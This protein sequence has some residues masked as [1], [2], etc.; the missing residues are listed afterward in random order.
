[1]WIIPYRI[2][3]LQPH[4]SA[5]EELTEALAGLNSGTSP[6]HDGLTVEF[7]KCFWDKLLPFLVAS[8]NAALSQGLSLAPK[9]KVSLL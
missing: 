2:S 5:G 6:G 4:L 1:M 8:F 3:F 9:E 7:Y